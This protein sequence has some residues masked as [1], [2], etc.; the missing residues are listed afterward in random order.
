HNTM[1]AKGHQLNPPPRRGLRLTALVLTAA[2]ATLAGITFGPAEISPAAVLR[3]F[4]GTELGSTRTIVLE[5]RL[6][7]ALAALLSGAALAVG[8][9]LMQT[10]FRNP[11]AGPFV[12]GI[13]SGASLAVALVVLGG[14]AVA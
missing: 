3:S 8:G 5:L 14:S 1:T 4:T 13:S 11:L 2:I 10:L 7:R 6:P 12:L 9:L